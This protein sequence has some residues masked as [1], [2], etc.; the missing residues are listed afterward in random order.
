MHKRSNKERIR[1]MASCRLVKCERTLNNG[2]GSNTENGRLYR[3]M[4]TCPPVSTTPVRE[5]CVC[6]PKESI[7]VPQT[8]TEGRYLI[9]KMIDCG[10][11]QYQGSVSQARAKELLAKGGN[12][13]SRRQFESEEV[14]VRAREQ[15]EISCSTN[16]YPS[17]LYPIVPVQCPPL[18]PP[19]APPAKA[20]PLTKNQKMW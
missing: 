9:S 14:R 2:S 18:P 1:E 7:Q 19:P 10:T 11:Y 13:A 8:L 17:S 5:D 20:C 6:K 3:M 4:K 12:G 16:P 15:E